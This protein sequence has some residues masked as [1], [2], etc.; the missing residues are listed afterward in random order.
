M[1]R[2]IDELGR[3]V[4]P[5]EIRRSMEVGPGDLLEIY[6]EG[7]SVILKKKEN[8]CTFCGTGENLTEFRDH[9]ICGKCRQELQSEQK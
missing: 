7:S 1:A 6:V 9:W 8:T 3:V 2:K 5:I 4:L